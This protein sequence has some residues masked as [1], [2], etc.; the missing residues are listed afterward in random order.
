MKRCILHI[1]MHKTGS[2]S[3]QE[4]LKDFSSSE[5]HYATLLRTSN[6]GGAINSAFAEDSRHL[7]RGANRSARRSIVRAAGVRSR[8]KRQFEQLDTN[9][10]IIS[11]EG[12]VKLKQS[13]LEELKAFI[14]QYTSDIIV[15]C[16]IRA[17]KSYMESALQQR[18]KAGLNFFDKAACYPNYR[19]RFEKFEVVFGAKSV[20]YW[21]FSSKSLKDQCVVSDFCARLGIP[22][23]SNDIVRVNESLSRNAIA[24]LYAYRKFHSDSF[25]TVGKSTKEN[26]WLIEKLHGL[27]GP[28]L[29]LSSSIVLPILKERRNDVDWMES[30]LERSLSEDLTKH[31]DYAISTEDDLLSFNAETLDWLSK[32]LAID[33]LDSESLSLAKVAELIHQLR[34]QL[35]SKCL[36]TDFERRTPSMEISIRK[37]VRQAQLGQIQQENSL[38]DKKAAELVQYIFDRIS[39]ELDSSV[40]GTVNVPGLGYFS[41]K[42]KKWENNLKSEAQVNRKKIVFKE[43]S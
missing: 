25:P 10:I 13:E 23:Q 37:L 15:V 30:R 20:R 34:T 12:I 4:S 28:K 32:E 6:H 19:S 24:A 18:I 43:Y 9:T 11:G 1:G 21:G 29:R 41:I 26:R 16:Y 2:S 7:R 36:N 35:S 42:S 31:D 40:S 14:T 8:L 33:H 5:F 17:P 3:I 38:S 27:P 22:I 39:G